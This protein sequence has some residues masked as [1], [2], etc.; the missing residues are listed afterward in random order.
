MLN[1]NLNIHYENIDSSDIA[2]AGSVAFNDVSGE[3]CT[4]GKILHFYVFLML[5]T[6]MIEHGVLD[7]IIIL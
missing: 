6:Q 2:V 3:I 5:L 4:I 7:L 1:S